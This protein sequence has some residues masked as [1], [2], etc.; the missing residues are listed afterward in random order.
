LCF[1]GLYNFLSSE[2]NLK[3]GNLAHISGC[4]S[5]KLHVLWYLLLLPLCLFRFSVLLCPRLL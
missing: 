5:S 3:L 4:I 1:S 2:D